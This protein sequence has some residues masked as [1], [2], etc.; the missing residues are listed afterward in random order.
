MFELVSCKPQN[1]TILK[2]RFKANV[3]TLFNISELN[4]TALFDSENQKQ[5]ELAFKK[6]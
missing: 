4:N 3:L 6:E 2:I 5:N 1:G